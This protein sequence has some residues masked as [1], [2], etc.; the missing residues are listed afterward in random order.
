MASF[1]ILFAGALLLAIA[2]GSPSLAIVSPARPKNINVA[3][4]S[5]WEGTSLLLEA[6]E[7]LAK[8]RDDFIWSFIEQWP[9]HSSVPLSDEACFN[10][11][12]RISSSI[13][14]GPLQPVFHLSLLLRSASPKV[15]LYRQLAEE[16]L[17]HHMGLIQE[18]LH[19]S[20]QCDSQ[21]EDDRCRT[22]PRVTSERK[23]CCWVDVGNHAFSLKSE[24]ADWLDTIKTALKDREVK[25]AHHSNV[26]LFEFDHIFPHSISSR[27]VAILYGSPGASCFGDLHSMLEEAAKL[28]LVKYVLRP[29]LVSECQA[30]Q[31]NCA[32]MGAGSKVLLGGYGVELA[33]KNMEYKAIDDS[34][35]KKNDA[36][37]EVRTDDL[38]EEVRG[39]IFSRLLERKPH[40]SDDLLTFR[41]HLLSSSVSDTMNVWELKDL[42]YQTAQRILHASESLRVMQDVNQNFPNLVSAIS[43]LKLNETIKDE[44]VANQKL[45][46][47]GKNMLAINGALI[48]LEGLDLHSLIELVLGELS[49]AD[50]IS[51]LKVPAKYVKSLMQIPDPAEL[52]SVRVDFRSP[53][54]YYLNNLEEDAMYRRW[55]SN[56]QELLMP[57]FPG[58]MRYIKK[59]LFNAVYIIDPATPSG[60]QVVDII[61]YYYENNVPM[62]FGIILTSSGAA[63]SIAGSGGELPSLGTRKDLSILAGKLFMYIEENHG[64]VAAFQFLSRINEAR[65]GDMESRNE[66]PVESTHIE[67]AFYDTIR[68][69]V[70]SPPEEILLKLEK[71]SDY[72]ENVL[73]STLFVYK[74]GLQELQPCL[75]MNGVVHTSTSLE[76]GLQAMSEELPKIQEGVYFGHINSHT[77]ILEK[78]LK[79]KAY[80]RYNLDIVATSK[81]D[82]KYVSLARAV[83]RGNQVLSASTFLHSSG[84]ED[85]IKAITHL[86]CVNAASTQGFQLLL[87]SVRYLMTGSKRGRV[88][89]LFNVA[90]VP[91]FGKASSS[92]LLV[93]VIK[94]ALRSPGGTKKV[95]PFLHSLLSLY[96]AHNFVLEESH[97][98]T[99]EK[100]LGFAESAKLKLDL[101]DNFLLSLESI[102]ECLKQVGEETQFV[103]KHLGL[104]PGTNAVITN[105][106][107]FLQSS[108]RGFVAEDFVLLEAVEFDRR[109]KP[110]SDI[111]EN[112][113]WEGIDPDDLTA[114]F[115]S[116]VIMCI[117]SEIALRNRGSDTARFDLLQSEHSAIIQE[118]E[119]AIVHV[120]AIVDPLSSTG[121]RLSP[122]FVLLQ[123]WFQASMR[124]LLNPMN[125][126]ADL[127]LKNFY[128]FVV[129]SRHPFNLDGSLQ[130]GPTAVFS[131]MP[132]TRTL[133][134]NLDVPEPWLVE[135]VDAIYDLDNIVLEKLGD[136]RTMYAVFELE[137]LMLTGHC[138]EQN[139][140]PPRGLQL[141]LGTKL[142]PHVV[143]TIVMAN[144]GYWQLKAAPGVWTLRLAPGR[145]SSLYTF[146]GPEEGDNHGPLTKQVVIKDLRGE[147]LHLEVVKRKGKENEAVLGADDDGDSQYGEHSGRKG[148]NQNLLKWAA[149][150]LGGS[151]PP[152]QNPSQ[153]KLMARTGEPIN[154]FSIASGHLYE[155]FLKIMMLSVLKNTRRPVKFWFIKNYLSPQFK[156]FIPHMAKEYG[157]QYDLVTYK[158]PTW[159]HKQTEKQRIIWAY[160]ILFLDV[161]FPLSLRKVIFVDADQIVR[162][163]MGELYD[164]DLKGR[165]LAYTPFC[166]NNKE[167]DGYRFWNQGFWKDHLRG[168][169]YHISALYVVDLKK[170]RQTAAG[171]NLRVFYET[172]SK[173]PGSLSNLDQ[174]LPN[175]AQHQVPI[176]S[177]PQE[178]LWCESWCGNATKGKA[179][180]I[181]LCNNPMTK[182]P[183][184]QGA[185]RIVAEW[186]ALDEEVRSLTSR[187]LGEA[188]QADVTVVKGGEADVAIGK[189]AEPADVKVGKDAEQFSDAA[190]NVE[191][192]SEL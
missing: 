135:P 4:Q 115:L 110:V 152:P 120:D 76:G 71:G 52:S 62:R 173:D 6:G 153:G 61:L 180:T 42:G 95:L 78:F 72:E 58:Q 23:P 20:S 9:P 37:D 156:N 130:S 81:E 21:E 128:R 49:L 65:G 28:G 172:L 47:P 109:V 86:I 46:N 178:W 112:V 63:K 80:F 90:D 168:R 142:N 16:S 127:P 158:W 22:S 126:L 41:D 38:S 51:K 176:F 87:Q 143:D 167:M 50:A 88:G 29:Y 77:D 36:M 184:L 169:P 121:Q 69:R 103:S 19:L 98:S 186:P 125:S 181:D 162:A 89:I 96:A 3:L 32:S 5:K 92:F 43:R 151:K 14:D 106:K 74:L 15:V 40:L 114:D 2:F 191:T 100:S 183:K 83:T 108:R 30:E 101:S 177:L 154:I 60:L 104:E 82:I 85:D 136:A 54:V 174:D 10:N 39:F 157:F 161:I 8:L 67:E 124:I 1:K 13:L 91:D 25:G 79:E 119:N 137:A 57:V 165:P 146:H 122:F 132:P 129:P 66:D 24:L 44:I 117:S 55:R 192:A 11:I 138:H 105:G 94:E 149:D 48:N 123:S 131:N 164:M 27:S 35:V 116:S 134:M 179:K 68:S 185:R 182:E 26:E 45:V 140:G 171:D 70:K 144:L 7:L 99:L 102:E 139:D 111:I 160:K 34:D 31:G 133:T 73:K 188:E 187:V 59:N 155:R 56:L 145:S 189:G 159:L 12:L 141:V 163:D 75:L 53:Y 148:W 107:L 64:A 150:F 170:F 113:E 33:L 166:D 18:S 147:L 93:R 118:S 190:S 175:Y 84:T 17:L 97:D